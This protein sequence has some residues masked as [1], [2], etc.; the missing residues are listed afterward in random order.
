MSDGGTRSP[1]GEPAGADRA[2]WWRPRAWLFLAPLVAGL[3]VGCLLARSALDPFQQAGFISQADRAQLVLDWRTRLAAVL[4]TGGV[5]S[6]LLWAALRVPRSTSIPPRTPWIVFGGCAAAFGATI[7]A[8]AVLGDEPHRLASWTQGAVVIAGLLVVLAATVSWGSWR[9]VL[10][11]GAGLWAAVLAAAIGDLVWALS[12]PAPPPYTP[13]IGG[14]DCI[15]AGP[16]PPL[17]GS[18]LAFMALI[19]WG[20]LAVV[21]L[22]AVAAT[23][24][25]GEARARRRSE[26][27]VG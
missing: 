26:E 5:F 20:Y 21:Q 11:S 12:G 1:A 27:P 24:I 2:A 10:F 3:V 6:S 7:G 13:C 16:D 14:M 15:A 4:A 23:W 9:A 19:L 22:V 8:Q 17:G 25:A 18:F